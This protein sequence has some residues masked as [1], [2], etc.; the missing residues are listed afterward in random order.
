MT[1]KVYVVTSGEYSDY[2]IVRVFSNEETAIKFKAS[3][4][5]FY[6]EDADVEEWTLDGGDVV[7]GF[8]MIRVSYYQSKDGKDWAHEWK[9]PMIDG[10]ST[11]VEDGYIFGE[12][13]ERKEHSLCFSFNLVRDRAKQGRIN[14]DR[15]LQIARDRYFQYKARAEG[16]S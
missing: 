14:Y 11:N 15:L 7:D 1:D 12:E 3:Y 6:R 2:H 9:Q 10:E 5:R 8:E 4:E 16:I 13:L